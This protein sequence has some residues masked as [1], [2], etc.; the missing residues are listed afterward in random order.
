MQVCIKLVEETIKL[1]VENLFILPLNKIMVNNL[2]ATYFMI[3]DQRMYQCLVERII[4][5]TITHPEVTNVVSVVSQCM[6]LP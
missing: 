1:R 6:H 5:L 3:R 4:S 2:K